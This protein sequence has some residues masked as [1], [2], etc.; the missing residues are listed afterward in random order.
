MVYKKQ[1]SKVAI[2]ILTWNDWLNTIDCINSLIKSN[3]VNYDIFIIDNN[4][5]QFN[6]DKIV[7][8][9]KKKNFN[10]IIIKHSLAKKK[11]VHTKKKNIYVYKIDKISKIRFAKNV[12]ATKA[13][14]IGIKYVLKN[15]YDYFVRLDCDF[16]VTKNFLRESVE[17]F[18]KLG[19]VATVSPKIY[20]HLKKKTNKIWWI[21]LRILKNYFKFQK[22]GGVN[23]KIEDKGQF[24]GFIETDSFCGCCTMFSSKIF[25]KIKKLDDDFFFG[26]EDIE[27]SF[28]LKKYGKLIVNLNSV[29]YHKVSQSIYVSGIKSRVYFETVGWLLL[30]KKICNKSDKLQGYIFF[31]LRAIHK[32]IKVIFKKDKDAN[33]GYL[34]GI[35]DF[36]LKYLF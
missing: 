33:I 8:W 35:K 27:A 11:I 26:P 34:L 1:T 17:T 15:N 4:S 29:T 18:E 12:G 2:L 32:L 5:N 21:G 31:I 24:K 30:I 14:N 23:R 9:I 36:F 3:Y 25:K 10:P 6:F 22:T 28:R 13:Y 19:N 7:N 20:Y 16:I